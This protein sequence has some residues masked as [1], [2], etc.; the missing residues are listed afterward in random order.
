MEE[1]YSVMTA[2]NNNILDT[3]V[4]KEKTDWININVKVKI[5]IYQ[6]STSVLNC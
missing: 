4:K 2:S 3:K 1:M 6:F 5:Q